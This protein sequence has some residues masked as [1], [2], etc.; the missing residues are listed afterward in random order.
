[1]KWTRISAVGYL[2]SR[3]LVQGLAR[4]GAPLEVRF[5]V[6][7]RCAALLHAGDVD[8]GLIP[9]IEYLARP[10]YVI[11]PGIAVASDGPVASVA[12]FSKVPVERVGRVALDQSSRTSAALLR[13]LCHERFGIAPS[14]EAA[15]PD[16]PGML[17]DHD[18]ALLIGDPALFADHEALGLLKVDLGSEWRSHT[19]LPF[20]WAFWVGRE[21]ALDDG[22]CAALRRARDEGVAARAAIAADYAQGN[23]EIAARVE[24]YLRE[25]VTHVLGEAHEAGLAR[26]YAS[27]AR[28]GLAPA[29]RDVRFFGREYQH[30]GG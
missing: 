22:V 23:A 25:N 30:T 9:S 29:A 4:A 10:D 15:A 13:V 1:M 2:N 5:D 8:V 24:T 18:A 28:L 3:P 26:F 14:F 17:R 6:P 21:H 20:V 19:G 11:V 27:A 12:M 7:S 16:L